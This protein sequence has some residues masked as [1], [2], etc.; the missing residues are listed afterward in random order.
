MPAIPVTAV[1]CGNHVGD[2]LVDSQ[3]PHPSS[4]Q[5]SN[6]LDHPTPVPEELHCRK[7]RHSINFSKKPV[8]IM[9]KQINEGA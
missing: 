4:P 8:E 5:T 3:P 1:R 9:E 6:T 2:N 7:Y